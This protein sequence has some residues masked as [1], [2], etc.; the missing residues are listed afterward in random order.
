MILNNGNICMARLGRFAVAAALMAGAHAV[1]AET[2]VVNSTYQGW[3]DNLGGT[4]GSTHSNMYTGNDDGR[5]INSWIAF[6]IPPGQ[7]NFASLTIKPTLSGDTGPSVIGMF[8]VSVPFTTFIDGHY[9]GPSVFQD[10]GSGAQYGATSVYT[11]EKTV[12][13]SGNAVYDINAAAGSYFVIGFSNLTLNALP[14]DTV[15]GIFL[16]GVGND[17]VPLQL[18]L[19]V[20]APVPEPGTWAMLAGGL[21]LLGWRARR[22]AG[23][24]H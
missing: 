22:R 19:E 15:G 14:A 17:Q 5:R 23:A 9:V 11:S 1:H 12:N 6:Y 2:Q 3:V 4:N 13:L 16:N 8:D 24:H 7:Y 20:A 10:L 21:G 18:N